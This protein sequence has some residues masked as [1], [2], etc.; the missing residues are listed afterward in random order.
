M[1]NPRTITV[2]EDTVTQAIED[3]IREAFDQREDWGYM[4]SKTSLIA[5][6]LI[7]RLFDDPP[8]RAPA[9][10]TSDDAPP[11]QRLDP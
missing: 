9:G 8:R 7:E 2:D 5:M 3:T 1:S 4:Q 10:G 11:E 6:I